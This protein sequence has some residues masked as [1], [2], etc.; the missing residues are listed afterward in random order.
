MQAE[1]DGTAVSE[2]RPGAAVVE[3][4]KQAVDP[5]RELVVEGQETPHGLDDLP[6]RRDV[7]APAPRSVLVQGCFEF[8]ET[9]LHALQ[10]PACQKQFTRHVVA[11]DIPPP[12]SRNRIDG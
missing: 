5:Q 9:V 2:E 6:G 3:P 1:V 11:V 12:G 7:F 8:L 4:E 10:C